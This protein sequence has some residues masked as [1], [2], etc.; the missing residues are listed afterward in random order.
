M[1]SLGLNLFCYI[2]VSQVTPQRV[3]ERIQASLFVDS[4]E[5]RQTSINRPWTGATTVG[6]LKV[7]CERFLGAGQVERAF[8][9]YALRNGQTLDHNTRASI[10]V[11]QFTERFL[12]SVL[13]ASSARIVVNSALQGR[14][15]GISDVISIVD[16]A[17]QVLEFNRALLQATIENI[18]QGISVVDQNLRLVVWNQRYLELFRFPDHLIRVGAPFDKVL[19]YNALNGEYGPG[20]PEEHVEL[21]MDNI[22]QGHPHRYVR[23]RQDDSVLEVQGNPMPGGGFVYTYQDITQ[24]KRTEEALIRS[25][26]NIRIYT[27]NVPALIAYFDKECRYLFTNRAYEQVFKVD[28]NAVIGERVDNVISPAVARE[29][30]PWMYRA[31]DGE[32]VSFEISLDDDDGGTRYLL[33]TYTPHFVDSGGILGFFALYQDITERRLA[34]IALKE[35]NENLE[36]RVRERTQALSEANA[37]LRQENRVRAEAEQALRQ[38]KQVAEDANTSKTRFLAAA[39]HD[40][41]QPLNAARLFTSALSQQDLSSAHSHTLGHIDNSLQAAEELLST[42]LDISKLDAGALTPRRSHFALA[43]IFRPLRAEFEVMADERGLDLVVVP[44]AQWIDSDAQMLRRIVQNFLSNALRYTQ[45]GRVLLGCRR[46]AGRLSIEVWD[47]GPGIPE[48]KQAEIFQEFRR[49]DQ[50]SRH[51]E[52]EKGLG[53]GLS[54]ADRMSRVLEHPLR[55]RSWEGI[56][57]VF[58]VEVPLVSAGQATKASEEPPR[59][60]VSNKLKGTRILCIDNETL[61]LEGMKA[62][63]TGWGCEVFTATSIGGAKSVLRH[64]DGD[65]DAILADYHLDNEV[66]G[67][68]ALEALLE[69]CHGPV[70]GIVITADRT[71]EVAEQI[72]RDGY[73]LLLKPVRPA[74]LRALLT[75]TLQASRGARQEN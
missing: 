75:R 63:L 23:Y 54:I 6:D 62:M 47:T 60:R 44:T 58:A 20:D 29:R 3:V 38:A 7:L 9:D 42:L 37:A 8:D 19:R 12:A 26:N 43:D 25:E 16:E 61:I 40:L 66:T 24:Q 35:T 73:Q 11:I 71:E 13:G 69:R 34:E 65:P 57:T 21:L 33:V 18:N 56:G 32:R 4:V 74:A 10:D 45:H 70:P 28:R 14:G 52:S 68:M 2:F 17:S 22:R 31:L 27:D 48:S 41:L 39:S 51:K 64:L 50:A 55:V 1:L 30:M 72:K 53:L 15:I 5:T 46:H 67:L 36:E 59:N 49:L